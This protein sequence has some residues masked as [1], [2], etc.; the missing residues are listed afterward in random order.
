MAIQNQAQNR[1]HV[2]S[3]S[4]E[5]FL[6]LQQRCL[7]LEQALLLK[8]Q[9][10]PWFTGDCSEING[11]GCL[12]TSGYGMAKIF[13]T[14]SFP[15]ECRKSPSEV[16]LERH[17]QFE[18]NEMEC[19]RRMGR[20]WLAQGVSCFCEQL[21]SGLPAVQGVLLAQPASLPDR[22]SLASGDFW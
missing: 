5:A 7:L 1:R 14:M 12:K 20:C 18:I 11:E 17:R 13:I 3:F 2:Y 10:G 21:C 6:W 8:G 9:T 22:K 16:C 19:Q 4:M 15:S